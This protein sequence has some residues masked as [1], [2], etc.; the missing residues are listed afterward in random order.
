MA[1]QRIHLKELF[2]KLPELINGVNDKL[3]VIAGSAEIS[4]M[5]LDGGE[6]DAIRKHLYRISELTEEIGFINGKIMGMMEGCDPG[7][8]RS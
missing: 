4:L 7:P 1:D 8:D 3:T 2:E 5:D 6:F